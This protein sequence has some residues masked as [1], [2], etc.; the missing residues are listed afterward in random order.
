MDYSCV[1]DHGKIKD[2]LAGAAVVAF[3]FETSPMEAYRAE[4]KAALDA[5]KA[6]ITGLYPFTCSESLEIRICS[7]LV[8]GRSTENCA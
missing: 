5:H 6:T 7:S 8:S 1:T 2:Y 3:D 4:G